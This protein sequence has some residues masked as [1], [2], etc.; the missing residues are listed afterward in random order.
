[1]AKRREKCQTLNEWDSQYQ[2]HAKPIGDVRL[3]PDKMHAYDCEPV[4]KRAN[5]EFIL[6]LGERRIVGATFRWDPS[7]GKTKSDKSSTALVFMMI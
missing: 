2:M 3:D 6:M 1:M 4:L 7:S 5:R